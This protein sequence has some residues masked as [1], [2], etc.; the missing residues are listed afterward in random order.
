MCAGLN[1]YSRVQLYGLV[2]A[3]F[4]VRILTRK[5]ACA[6]PLYYPASTAMHHSQIAFFLLL[7]PFQIAANLNPFDCFFPKHAALGSQNHSSI[8]LLCYGT[9]CPRAFKKYRHRPSFARQLKT[10]GPDTNTSPTLTSLYL[11]HLLSDTS[12]LLC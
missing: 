7:T 9:H 4:S 10:T 1:P 2:R 8:D 12:F 5:V 3:F 11:S 6:E